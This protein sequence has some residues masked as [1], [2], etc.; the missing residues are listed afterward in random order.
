MGGV[1]KPGLTV[2]GSTLLDLVLTATA[3]AATTVVVGPE[4]ATCLPVI[5]TREEPVGAGP[6]AALVAGLQL[7]TAHVVVLLAADLPF[8]TAEVV[9]QLVDSLVSD[10]VVLVDEEGRDQYL[11]SAWKTAA[12]RE[13]DL[14]VNRL[15]VVVAG[16]RARR[17]SV[18]PTADRPGPWTDCD[19][20]D[21]LWKARNWA[22]ETR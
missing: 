1:D 5:W 12:L 10:G 16:L 20:E 19:T 7:V 11:C 17:V 15:S 9:G 6:V 2:G 18:P 14:T 3:D 4:R 22:G 21:D 8:L 13:A